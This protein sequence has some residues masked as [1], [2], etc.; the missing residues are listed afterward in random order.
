MIRLPNGGGSL[1]QFRRQLG[2]E[3]RK[4]TELEQT[5]KLERSEW[6]KE[7]KEL[8]DMITGEAVFNLLK[9]VII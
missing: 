6:A 5:V 2:Q 4:R 9:R 8:Q 7:R 1:E 3:E